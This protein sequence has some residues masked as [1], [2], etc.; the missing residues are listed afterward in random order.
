MSDVLFP[1]AE[2][3][4]RLRLRLAAIA[5]L[6]GA[7]FAAGSLWLGLSF[8]G[9]V[10]HDLPVTARVTTLGDSLG[11]NSSVKFRGLRIGRVLTLE[12]GRAADGTYAAHIVIQHRYADRVPAD[13]VA[14]VLPGTIFGAEYIDLVP[15]GLSHSRS[16]VHPAAAVR[17]VP[18]KAGDVISADTSSATVR[19]MDTFDATQ[20]VLG[21]IDPASMDEALSQLATALDG[22]G[23]D[24]R[25]FIGRADRLVSRATAAEPTF[26]AD[27]ALISRNLDTVAGLEPQLA[28]ALR[29]SLPVA[30][31]IAGKARELDRLVRN[32]TA[33]A[34]QLSGFLEQHGAQL[35]VLLTAVAPTYRAFVG[36]IDPFEAILRLAPTVLRNGAA[37]IKDGAI[38]MR[39]R[40]AAAM[41]EPYSAADCPRYGTVAGRNCR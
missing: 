16:G 20:R 15:A 34:A 29:N 4:L 2:S 13:V 26:Y 23:E 35:T 28:Q 1:R 38:Q 3:A 22:R 37:A 27:L 21:A 12:P 6:A 31:T 40:F 18:L 14:R 11:V 17:Q 25:A 36:G 7:L 24:L 41:F 19:L 39:A 30:R 8:I 33:L 10:G 5:T 9:V 32:S